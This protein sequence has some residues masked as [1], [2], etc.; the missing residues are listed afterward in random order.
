MRSSDSPSTI[1]VRYLPWIRLAWCLIALLSIWNFV[2]TLILTRRFAA[3]LPDRIVSG[4]A[5]LGWTPEG[6]FWFTVA[7]IAPLFLSFFALGALIFWLR[8]TDRVAAFSSVFMITFAAANSFSPAKEY[9]AVV[10]GAPLVIFI[11]NVL[12]GIIAF[13]FLPVFF[14]TFPDGRF[15]PGWMRWIA[16]ESFIFTVLW[17]IF[18]EYVGD[19]SGPYGMLAMVAALIMFGGSAAAQIIRYRS[20]ATPVQ[21]QQTK[22]FLFGLLMIM[23]FLIAP[24]F[25]LYSVPLELITAEASVRFD[26]FVA[27]ANLAFIFLPISIA[28]AVL[29]YRL[30][31]IDILIR[32]TL[33]YALLTGLLALIYFGGVVLLQTLLGPLTGDR[34]SPLVTVLSTLA[35][36]ALF[37]PLRSRVQAFIDRRLYR[38]KYDAEQSLARFAAAAR[39][40][41]DIDRL[42]DALLGVVEE[43]MRPERVEIRLR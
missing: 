43:T 41:V 16:I 13:G 7:T 27:I 6:W 17:N 33:Q 22:W 21:K 37:N 18:P 15:Y 28:F 34:N 20:Y 4:L 12:V 38:Q 26:S 24:S 5:A 10:A 19:F 32:R 3:D 36:A 9:L 25:Y 1:P 2:G 23:V 30:W 8:A 11:P 42:A 29:R 35:I 14:A 31:D 39:S 40:E